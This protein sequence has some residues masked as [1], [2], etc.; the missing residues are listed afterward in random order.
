MAIT[1]VEYVFADHILF[2]Y[3]WK[4]IPHMQTIVCPVLYHDKILYILP[5]ILKQHEL[6]QVVLDM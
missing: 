2:Q 4:Q 5:I 3:S 1:D 6:F